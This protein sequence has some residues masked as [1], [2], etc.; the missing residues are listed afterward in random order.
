MIDLDKL[1]SPERLKRLHVIYACVITRKRGEFCLVSFADGS[2]VRVLE[3]RPAGREFFSWLGA[4]Q[5]AE[6]S[7]LHSTLSGGQTIYI[8]GVPEGMAERFM[9]AFKAGSLPALM[10]ASVINSAA[11]IS[12]LTDQLTET[13]GIFAEIR[14]DVT[15][16]TG[17]R[18]FI[19][20]QDFTGPA[21]EKHQ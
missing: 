9:N 17:Y 20:D 15:A 7:L 19:N 2:R 6:Q 14:S 1:M 16:P 12:V 13:R 10:F 5:D 4:A 8:R 3:R 18:V 11:S 21:A